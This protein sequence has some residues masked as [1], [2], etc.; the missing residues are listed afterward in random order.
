[1]VNATFVG[2]GLHASFRRKHRIRRARLRRKLQDTHRMYYE[3][4]KVYQ[5]RVMF[6]ILVASACILTATLPS[7]RSFWSKQ[8][9]GEWWDYAYHTFNDKEWRENFRVQRTTFEFLVRTLRVETE[10]TDTRFRKAV[11]TEKRVAVTLWRLA[12]NCEYRTIGHLFGIGRNTA[13]VIVR[14]VCRAI[15]LIL[16]PRFISIPRGQRLNE[17][18]DGFN[19]KGF[20]QCVGAIDGTHIPI[21]APTKDPQDFYNRKCWHSI[22]VQAVCDHEFR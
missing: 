9:P 18:I 10:K 11:S 21:I 4:L 19:R 15:K 8:R 5:L 6:N 13:C 14:D 2:L 1:M 16:T 22:I 17:V 20:P 3:Y 7:D 12:T